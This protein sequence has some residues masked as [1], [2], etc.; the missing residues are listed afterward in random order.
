M[1]QKFNGQQREEESS[2]TVLKLTLTRQ[3]KVPHHVK[4][5]LTEH[6]Y[7]PCIDI[8]WGDKHNKTLMVKVQLLQGK[9]AKLILDKAKH[10][11]ATEA[12][13]ELDWL[14]LE[15][16]P[17]NT[18]HKDDVL[19]PKCRC[20]WGQQRLTYQAIQEWNGLP[21]STRNSNSLDLFMKLVCC[22]FIISTQ[23]QPENHLRGKAASTFKDLRMSDLGKKK[24]T[25]VITISNAEEAAIVFN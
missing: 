24:H 14:V 7:N 15:T 12:I 23:D 3:D 19:L 21:V 22:I 11:S 13:N 6:I 18:R 2:V 20:Q 17:Y 9:A 4:N 1:S 25:T 10:S 16:H 5:M 8:V